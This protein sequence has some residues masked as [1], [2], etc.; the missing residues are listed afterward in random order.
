MR[1]R[2][3]GIGHNGGPRLVEEEWLI[4]QADGGWK[5]SRW[6][7][8]HRR[9]WKTPPREIALRRLQLAEEAGMTCRE[10]TLELLERGVYR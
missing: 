5:L 10:Y 8:A 4:D 9:A 1:T 6:R 3:P 7:A 2:V